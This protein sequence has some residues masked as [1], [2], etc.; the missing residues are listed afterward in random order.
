MLF[1]KKA[2]VADVRAVFAPQSAYSITPAVANKFHPLRSEY[3]KFILM[4]SLFGGKPKLFTKPRGMSSSA[5]IEVG[6]KVRSRKNLGKALETLFPLFQ[7][8]HD[9]GA[10]S[11][12]LAALTLT[13]NPPPEDHTPLLEMTRDAFLAVFGEQFGNTCVFKI[14]GP[15]YEIGKAKVHEPLADYVRGTGPY[16]AAA[17]RALDDLISAMNKEKGTFEDVS[18]RVSVAKADRPEGEKVPPVYYVA[19]ERRSDVEDIVG[20]KWERPITHMTEDMVEER[21]EETVELQQYLLATRTYGTV[22]T[23]RDRIVRGVSRKY[24]PVLEAMLP[25]SERSDAGLKEWQTWDEVAD[26]VRQS[27]KVSKANAS[28]PTYLEKAL[29]G[30]IAAEVVRTKEDEYSLAPDFA[31]LLHVSYY[32]LGD[33]KD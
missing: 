29:A 15:V 19:P 14:S 1:G 21:G 3:G 2:L 8:V 32:A 24:L 25:E 30:L 33:W 5:C 20:E 23:M 11:G 31:D 10:S 22:W 28:S 9:V 17:R 26:L 4:G 12:P 13:F 27:P 6:R 18:I 16:S 7:E